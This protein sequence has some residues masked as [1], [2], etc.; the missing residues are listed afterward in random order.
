M[1]MLEKLAFSLAL[2]V[3]V[4]FGTYQWGY[5]N[6]EDALRS[7]WNKERLAV[8]AA[9]LQVAT[10]HAQ[11]MADLVTMHNQTNLKNA[12]QHET[13]LSKVHT[14]LAAARAESKRLGGLRIPVKAC[15]TIATNAETTGTSEHHEG[16]TTT[17]AL[18]E[19]IEDGLWSIVGQADEVTE[20]LRACQG[21]IIDNGFYGGK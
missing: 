20:Q 2:I 13:A 1:G 5:A 9:Q 21:W 16:S 14:D 8:K 17:I 11:A 10:Q 6:G 4:L 18:P 12:K 3:I 19:P 15:P 7:E